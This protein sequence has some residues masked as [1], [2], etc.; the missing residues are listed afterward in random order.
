MIRVKYMKVLYMN[1]IYRCME[2]LK[3]TD[4]LQMER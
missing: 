3:K 1:V 4:V 2:T